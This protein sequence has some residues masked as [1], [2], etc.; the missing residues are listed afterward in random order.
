MNF[1]Q[2]DTG[3]PLATSNIGMNGMKRA[4]LDKKSKIHPIEGDNLNNI[5]NISY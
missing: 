5:R 3:A 1:V 4:M 2:R